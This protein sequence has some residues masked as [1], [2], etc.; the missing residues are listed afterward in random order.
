[1][2]LTTAAKV[3]PTSSFRW[4]PATAGWVVGVIA[5]LSL[6]A[7]ISPLVRS[8]IRIP[9]EF[10][11]DYIFNFPDTSFAWAFVLA[12]LAAALA[13]RKRIAW[14]IL[15]LY[16]VAAA[17]WN[18]VD[19]V[20]GGERWFQE[21]GELIGLAFHVAAVV[22][23]LSA[24][25][26]FWARV[27]RG[28]LLKAAGVL[29][30]AMGVGTLIGW[31]LLEFFPGTLARPDRFWYALNRVSAFAGADADTFTGHPHVF[32]NALLGLFGALALMAAAIVLFQ[33]QRADNALT[34]EDE[35]A[36]RGLLE[37]YGKNDSLGYFATRRD[38]AV[39]FAP[40]GRAAITY[41]VEVGVCLASGDPVG[42]EK[43]WPQAIEAWLGLCQSYGWAPGVMGASSTGAQ[44]F[45][46]A[47]LNALQLGDEAILHPDSF[48][49]TGPD[50][51][52]VRQAV[53]RARRAGGSVRI[54]RHRDIAADEMAQV[55]T[56]A[57][58][59]R[60]TDDERGFSMALGRLGDPADGDCLLVE[61]VQND[62]VVAMLSLVPWGTNGASLDLMRRSPQSPNGTIELMVSELCMQSE[63]IG[64]TRVSL[65]FAMFRSAFEQ[66][67]QLGAGPVA[68][69]WRWLLVFFSRWWQLETLYRS[70][71][72]YQPDWV[73]RFACYEDARL[74]PRVGVASVIAEG[75]LVLPFSRRHEQPHTGHHIAAP[76][77]LVAT[78]LLHSDG[79]TPDVSG[80]AV[81]LPDD[82]QPR[83][84]EQVRVRM[85][86]LRALQDD[87]VDAYP[88]GSPPSHTVTQALTAADG[89]E[90]T[91]AGRVLRLRDY[92]GVLFAQLRDWSGE[93][94]LLL[95]NSALS[96]GGA[97]DFTRAI[98]LGDL[99]EVTGTVGRS[100]SGAWS[101]LVTN[102]R[103]IGK[104]LRP[105]PDKWKG[106]TDQEAR[107]R[108]RYVDLAINT[109]ARD[110][111]RARSGVLHAIRETLVG[112]GFL[113]VETP[114]LQQIHGGAN[115]RPFLTHI[116]A[117]DLDLYL[118]IAPELYLKRLC[119]GGVERVFELG[120][121]FRNEGVDFSHNPEFTLLEAY[122]AHADYHVWIDGCRELIQNAAQAA[123]GAH[124]FLRPRE[125]GTLE[126][127]DISGRWT[128]KTVH[129]AV[130]EALG[131]HIDVGTELPALRRLCD[132]AGIPYL[133]H[134][135]TGAV[136]LEM[137]E[138]LV[139]DRT[140]E[141]TFY[142]DFPTSVSP[143][144]RPH[145]STPGL[146]ERWD[147]VAWGV[148]LGTA[149]S[150]LT[151]PVEQRRRLQE[152]SLLASGGDP[153]AMELD[154]DFLQAMEYAMPPTG[155]LGMGVDRVVML[156]TGR[157][158]RE[159]L[160]FPLAKPR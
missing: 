103:L 149:Y 147:L 85:A 12:L 110:L 30:A 9:R 60:D 35:S 14:L 38:K 107:V 6:L 20:E 158:I 129:D 10:V 105:L 72:K 24:R 95:E 71:M 70:N 28:A 83:L 128:V 136:V 77:T 135:D 42:D 31:A 131:E 44:A 80:L 96:D 153:E 3:R 61:A 59:W 159:T 7:S 64:V 127:V 125:D 151:D 146:A 141:P 160:P 54:R 86:K 22:F 130:S 21:V 51:R 87:G 100:R 118:R 123:N 74:V 97:A 115:A 43:S 26:E 157:S 5:T 111:I 8:T 41:R 113:E 1:M 67:A 15:V 58:A 99:I 116:N 49:L 143:L 81:D 108:A 121:A 19:L 156:I 106:L 53:T 84:P 154:E 57:D 91:V 25:K 34:G 79:T 142:K 47:G 76:G 62:Q 119:V 94:Q 27:R 4:V 145:R 17:G 89:A 33:S 144:T 73:P 69:L 132:K 40:N 104:C 124:V 55:I 63:D 37:L 82:D 78:G 148:E 117:Y 56:R 109:E 102:W 90:V 23:L 2:T 50:M 39:V 134:W 65:N 29:V 137:Y 101:I 126:P 48:R 18:I 75:F 150:E 93:A 68:R 122:Q 36:I 133:T 139:E 138:H 92:G 140:T 98:D 120:R 13:A 112:K 52:A 88:V 45:R 155:G 11:N 46:A 32:V 152:Q 114:I 66:G 16:M